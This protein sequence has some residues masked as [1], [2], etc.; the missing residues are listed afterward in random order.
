VVVYRRM[1]LLLCDER[2]FAMI[3]FSEGMRPQAQ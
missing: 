1:S 2:S 3:L